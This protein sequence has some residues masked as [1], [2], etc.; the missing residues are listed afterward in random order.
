M[1]SVFPPEG[2]SD[3]QM[4]KHIMRITHVEPEEIFCWGEGMPFP[5]E[6]DLKGKSC[7]I[8]RN[9]P[10]LQKVLNFITSL[11]MMWLY[12]DLSDS[13]FESVEDLWT[14][15]LDV[16]SSDIEGNPAFYHGVKCLNVSNTRIESVPLNENLKE[17]NVRNCQ[18]LVDNL[19]VPRNVTNLDLSNTQVQLEL[20][21]KVFETRGD[22][23][24]IEVLDL[25]NCPKITDFSMLEGIRYLDIRDTSIP[26]K[27]VV[28]REGC[29][30]LFGND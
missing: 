7:L 29:T 19:L 17:L 9:V 23:I 13:T 10:D 18:N 12:V 27:D 26:D 8:M 5:T 16:S 30:V 24:E 28:I 25:N 1:I 20:L 4:F 3:F 22:G 6:K 2:L 14:E 11:H 21:E 15:I